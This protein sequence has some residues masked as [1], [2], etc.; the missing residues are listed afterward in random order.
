MSGY[1]C[2]CG[3]QGVALLKSQQ[4]IKGFKGFLGDSEPMKTLGVVTL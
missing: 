3:I 4:M 2:E 1:F